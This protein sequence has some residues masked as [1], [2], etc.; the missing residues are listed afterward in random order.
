MIKL[1]QAMS[2][3]PEVTFKSEHYDS[4]T[5]TITLNLNEYTDLDYLM[6]EYRLKNVDN[7]P[8]INLIGSKQKMLFINPTRSYSGVLYENKENKLYLRLIIE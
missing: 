6:R 7:I 2:L 1:I 5:K 3:V 4:N 8:E